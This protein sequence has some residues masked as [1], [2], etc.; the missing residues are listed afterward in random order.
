MLSSKCRGT[1]L[2]DGARWSSF[3]C[4]IESI[5]FQTPEL[6]LLL[7]RD[8]SPLCLTSKLL[9][10]WCASLKRSKR[11]SIAW[12]DRFFPH[13]RSSD[14]LDWASCRLMKEVWSSKWRM[15]QS[16]MQGFEMARWIPLSSAF[17]MASLT[18]GC[19]S[20]SNMHQISSWARP[21]PLRWSRNSSFFVLTASLTSDIGTP[22]NGSTEIKRWSRNSRRQGKR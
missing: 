11:R 20:M 13:P 8:P 7:G 17:W 15:N 9:A 2:P 4:L 21:R 16:S 3:Y 1:L 18:F 22:W 10:R 14:D 6:G 12:R 5:S 19:A